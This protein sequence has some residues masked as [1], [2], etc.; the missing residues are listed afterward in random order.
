M[1]N[2]VAMISEY[3]AQNDERY[4]ALRKSILEAA[5][6]ANNDLEPNVDCYNRMHAPC[7]GYNWDGQE[8]AKGSYLPIPPE[9]REDNGQSPSP[10]KIDHG[11]TTKVK[12]N[13]D[14]VEQL[15]QACGKCAEVGAGVVWDD[16]STCYAYIKT[17][18][19][20]LKELVGVYLEE[21]KKEQIRL[22]KKIKAKAPV[23]RRSVKGV[24]RCLKNVVSQFGVTTKMLIEAENKSTMWGTVPNNLIDHVQTNSVIT[25]TATFE[26]SSEDPTHAFFKRPSKAVIV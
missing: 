20:G 22:N 11:Y 24:V 26:P 7:H 10:I 14:E 15:K 19:K 18:R 12:S 23:G 16:N 6:K 4:K 3:V 13:L 25:F 5:A 21:Q 17:E 2:L 1:S 8:Y 9:W